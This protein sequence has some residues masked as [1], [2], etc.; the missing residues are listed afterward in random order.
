MVDGAAAAQSSTT[1]A[2]APAIEIA[3]E[4]VADAAAASL[5]VGPENLGPPSIRLGDPTWRWQWQPRGRVGAFAVRLTVERR[6]G[7]HVVRDLR[8]VVE[9]AK[10]PHAAYE[11]LL[12]DI[13]RISYALVYALGGGMAPASDRATPETT[14]VLAD[15]WTRLAHLGAL[16]TS[17]T[18]RKSTRLNSSHANI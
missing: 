11:A 6:D 3:C 9:P 18:D 4:A 12:A 14:T 13:Q 16:A 5:A 10:L 1:A 8:L 7:E 17:I 15:Y 2:E